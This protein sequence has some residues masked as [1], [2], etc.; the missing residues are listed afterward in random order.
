MI[1]TTSIQKSVVRGVFL[2]FYALGQ[3]CATQFWKD[4]YK[5]TNRVP[6]GLV[7]MSHILCSILVIATRQILDAENKRRDRLK[8]EAEKTG[9]GRDKFEDWA[10]VEV[11]KD[12]KIV[13]EKVDK[14]FLDL[15]DKENLAFRYVL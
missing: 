8:A 15:T 11:E 7:L 13:K 4:K 12:G 2:V 9:I 1:S 14:S 6:F 10:I 5:P 3:I